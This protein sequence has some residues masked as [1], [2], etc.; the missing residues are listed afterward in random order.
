MLVNS[1]DAHDVELMTRV[2]I[3]GAGLHVIIPVP[4]ARGS[5]NCE[6]YHVTQRRRG[7]GSQTFKVITGSPGKGPQTKHTPPTPHEENSDC[8]QETQ[9]RWTCLFCASYQTK[10]PL[11]DTLNSDH[12]NMRLFNLKLIYFRF[13]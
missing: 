6:I 2:C 11:Y 9:V 5:L 4:P 3:T 7:R 12:G 10:P 1:Q 8:S 13:F